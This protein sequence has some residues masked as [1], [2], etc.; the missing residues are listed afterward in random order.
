MKTQ[1]MIFSIRFKLFSTL[2]AATGGVVLCMY[3]VMQWTFNNGF[4]AHVNKQETLKY[5]SFARVLAQ[6]WKNP[7]SWQQL[8]NNRLH[9]NK[10][11]KSGMG[12]EFNLRDEEI[13][14][15]DDLDLFDFQTHPPVRPGLHLPYLLDK[16][17]EVIYGMHDKLGEIKRYPIE[18]EGDVVGYL[19]QLPQKE[20]TDRLDLLFVRQQTNAFLLVAVLMVVISIVA[21]LPIAA[22]IV[23]PIKKLS[24]GTER[25]IAGKYKTVIPVTSKDE[26]GLLSRHFNSLANTLKENEQARRRWVA[27]ISHEL[28]T[29]LSILKGEI[30]A[31]VDG[32]TKPTPEAIESLHEE[33]EHLNRLVNDL[34]ELSMSDIGA[35]NYI[36]T[37]LD[38]IDLLSGTLDTYRGEF[39]QQGL[40]LEFVD[41]D[42]QPLQMLAD[43]SRLKQLFSNILSN[44]LRYT[45][46]PGKLLV[47]YRVHD[48]NVELSFKDS[49]PGVIENDIGR[50]FERL[51]RVESSRNRVTGG[52][53]LGLSICHNIVQAHEGSIS[54]QQSPFGGVWITVILPTFG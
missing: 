19:G 38:P 53:G 24:Q 10:L 28:R 33:S 40:T 11:L 14:L 6:E 12:I 15:D 41:E 50:L 1:T 7:G 13:I 37:D 44:T 4:L 47:E 30:E 49:S 43:A 35:L 5:Q 18:V 22:H 34:Y 16:N 39:E 2:L 48:G 29:P 26:L 17:A 20:L 42:Q 9:W 21:V 27:D 3:L 54:A 46:S 45:D 32:V 25:L 51:Y 36:K 8:Q 23:K 52:A 31:L